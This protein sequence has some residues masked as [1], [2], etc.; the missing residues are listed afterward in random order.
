MAVGAV[1][2]AMALAGCQPPGDGNGAAT[3][4]ADGGTATQPGDGGAATPSA[5]GD[6][7]GGSWYLRYKLRRP[8]G[9][10]RDKSTDADMRLVSPADGDAFAE[11]VEIDFAPPPGRC[12][13]ATYASIQ[14]SN[15]AAKRKGFK[16]LS[17][18]TLKLAG[19]D[20]VKNIYTYDEDGR[21]MKAQAYFFLPKATG[22][23]FQ[24]VATE[25][26][27]DTYA[28]IFEAVLASLQ[29]TN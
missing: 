1:T 21:K 18:E 20:C 24:C 3:R 25:A 11:Y 23:V 4:A 29:F 26:T 8:K 28:P 15:I 17:E 9:W 6:E 19:K 2:F 10:T 13:V 5:A 16:E 27:Y 7:K 12:R 14:L 22:L